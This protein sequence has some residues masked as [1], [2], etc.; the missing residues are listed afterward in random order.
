MEIINKTPI[1]SAESKGLL[2][3]VAAKNL[4]YEQKMAIE[5]IKST[6]N[7]T[8]TEAQKLKKELEGLD[9]RRLKSEGIVKIIDLLPKNEEELKSLFAGAT[10]PPKKEDL[11][12]IFKI[13]KPYAHKKKK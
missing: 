4:S 6:V 5:T 3:K 11:E 7:L 9:N 13:V 10:L 12:E 2:S 1:T 8:K